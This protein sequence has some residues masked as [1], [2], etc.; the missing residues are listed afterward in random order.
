MTHTHLTDDQIIAMCAAGTAPDADSDAGG[1][2][3]CEARR[4]D[5]SG[6]MTDVSAAAAAEAD[7]AFPPARV[8]RQYARIMS[9][10]EHHGQGGRVLAFP[11][12]ATQPIVPAHR[13]PVRRWIAGAAAAGLIIGMAA[14]H[15]VHELPNL[16][17]TRQAQSATVSQQAAIPLR[18]GTASISDDEFLREIET[19]I[20][21]GP[22]GL[23][24]LD[25]LTPVAWEIP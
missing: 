12:A 1:C 19:A 5:L 15:F 6:L 17:D 20:T 25:A 11:H 24:R 13:H 3:S 8:A 14:G 22:A 9:R 21:M 2:P 23:R 16:R 4:A 7:R 18:P 10:I